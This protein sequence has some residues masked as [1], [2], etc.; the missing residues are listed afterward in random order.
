MHHCEAVLIIY[1]LFSKRHCFWS[2][3]IKATLLRLRNGLTT[4]RGLCL[5]ILGYR[6]WA[7][8]ATIHITRR[9]KPLTLSE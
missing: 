2:S 1:F 9:T 7:V 5:P 6:N 3:T 4:A 8:W